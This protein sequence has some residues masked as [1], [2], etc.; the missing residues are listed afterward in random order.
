VAL[1][2]CILLVCFVCYLVFRVSARGAR[3]LSPIAMNITVRIM[4]L[5]LAS[6]AIQFMLNA[7]RQLHAD[8]ALLPV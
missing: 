4:G 8:G 7:I 6:V 5:L 1:Y 3:W 2:L